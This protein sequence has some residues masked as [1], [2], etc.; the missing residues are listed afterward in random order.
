MFC[1]F[2]AGE[3]ILGAVMYG[4]KT[5]YQILWLTTSAICISTVFL[6]FIPET[7]LWLLSKNK[8]NR[9]KDSL[10][11]IGSIKKGDVA[12]KDTISSSMYRKDVSLQNIHIDN[13]NDR[14]PKQKVPTVISN[15]PTDDLIW[16]DTFTRTIPSPS[17]D[18]QSNSDLS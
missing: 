11:L 18:N 14:V 1:S 17:V 10:I 9:L 6:F 13:D 12:P 8:F 16:R 4:F 15:N 7:P 3:I 2:S 5:T